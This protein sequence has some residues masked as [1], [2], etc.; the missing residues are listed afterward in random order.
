[1]IDMDGLH[2]SLDE[3]KGLIPHREPFLFVDEIIEVIPGESVV[4]KKTFTGKED[5]FKGHFPGLPILPGVIIVEMAA[6]ISAFMILT[7]PS[8]KN[9]FGLFTGIEK[10]KFIKK[11]S[12]DTTLIVKSRILLFRHNFAKSEAQVFAGDE[13]VAEGVVSATFVDKSSFRG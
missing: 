2:L 1:V 5:F 9:L 10:F 8:F 11:I 4:G 3:L 6:Q 7:I 13:L 12:S